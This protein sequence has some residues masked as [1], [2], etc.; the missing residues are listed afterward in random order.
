[1]LGER[2]RYLRVIQKILKIW[3]SYIAGKRCFVTLLFIGS[4]DFVISGGPGLPNFTILLV[5]LPELYLLCLQWEGVLQPPHHPGVLHPHT[6]QSLLLN[7]GSNF[8]GSFVN[9]DN[10]V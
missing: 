10:S 1:M 9:Y 6:T 8:S 7:A 5:I 3:H 4:N 2:L